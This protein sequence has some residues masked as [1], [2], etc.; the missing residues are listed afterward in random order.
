MVFL[1]LGGPQQLD[2]LIDRV[3]KELEIDIRKLNVNFR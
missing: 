1:L 3:R 2:E